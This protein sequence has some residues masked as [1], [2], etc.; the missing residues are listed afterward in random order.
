[1]GWEMVS[2]GSQRHKGERKK[3]EGQELPM[4]RCAGD[5]R[6]P[7]NKTSRGSFSLHKAPRSITVKTLKILQ[8]TLEM[9]RVSRSPRGSLCFGGRG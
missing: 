5:A 2:P 9:G 1:M 7:Q 4:G 3:G 8:P 6:R